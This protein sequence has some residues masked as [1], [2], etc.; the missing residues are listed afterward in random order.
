M[1]KVLGLK[2]TEVC[3]VCILSLPWW[4][5][6]IADM[7]AEVDADGSGNIDFIEFLN[8]MGR[9]LAG[10]K[11]QEQIK[12]AFDLIDFTGTGNIPLQSLYSVHLGNQR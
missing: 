3:T 2:F 12:D 9:K 8:M 7:V 4:Q 11:P 6:Q 10:L 1:V 5:E